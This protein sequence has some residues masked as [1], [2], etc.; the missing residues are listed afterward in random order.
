M[1][2]KHNWTARE[3]SRSLFW[4]TFSQRHLVVAPNCHAAG[5][6]ADL[7]IVRHDLRLMDVEIKISRKDL[8]EDKTKD[9]WFKEWDFAAHGW[10]SPRPEEREPVG[11]PNKI[12]KHYYALPEEIWDEKLWPDI[13]PNSGVI[14][15][16]SNS[17]IRPWLRILKQAKPNRAAQPIGLDEFKKIANSLSFRMWRACGELDEQ[18]RQKIKLSGE[19]A[20]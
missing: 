20:A 7:L 18:R 6:E 10:R 9:K 8:K 16:R 13:Q 5:Y 14:L 11:H 19:V 12:W 17:A 3:I 1:A 4:N 2:F 15:I